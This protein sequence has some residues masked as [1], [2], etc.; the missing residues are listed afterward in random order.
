MRSLLGMTVLCVLPSAASGNED[1]EVR[2]SKP[3]AHAQRLAGNPLYAD[4]VGR[5]QERRAYA[6]NLRRQINASRPPAVY[7]RYNAQALP[8]FWSAIQ[9]GWVH[10]PPIPWS[11]PRSVVVIANTYPQVPSYSSGRSRLSTP[12]MTEPRNPEATS[13][14]DAYGA[15]PFSR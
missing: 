5:L 14:S 13:P 7:H 10:Q 12:P 9:A 8:P 4:Y 6:L 15:D 3:G 1:F 2:I 11:G